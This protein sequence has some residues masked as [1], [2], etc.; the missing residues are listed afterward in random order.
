MAFFL[1]A[2]VVFLLFFYS[3][4]VE[5]DVLSHLGEITIPTIQPGSSIMPGKVNPVMAEFLIQTGFHVIGNHTAC[6]AGLD[7]GELD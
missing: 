3:S 1:A 5:S 2:V 7:H 4:D 6:S